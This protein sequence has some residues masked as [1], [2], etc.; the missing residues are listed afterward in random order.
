MR[1][2]KD[3]WASRSSEGSALRHRYQS[4]QAQQLFDENCDKKET[5]LFRQER[6]AFLSLEHMG[7]DNI[8]RRLNAFILQHVHK[9]IPSLING[10]NE[11]I[12]NLNGK[13][14]KLG[15]PR[16]T[17]Q[18][19]KGYLLSI[20]SGFKRIVNQALTGMFSDDFFRAANEPAKL[21]DFRRLRAVV[22]E[23]NEYFADAMLTRGSRR[24]IIETKPAL[25]V[26]NVAKNSYTKSPVPV[27]ILRSD[28]KTEVKEKM[29]GSRG[30]EL[31]GTANQFIIGELFQDHAQPW[32]ELAKTHA[33][34]VWEAVRYFVSLALQHLA[35]SHTYASILRTIVAPELATLKQ[36]LLEKLDEL[37]AHLSRSPPL[38]LGKAFL[39]KTQ[40]ARSDRVRASVVASL[41]T[42]NDH[43]TASTYGYSTESIKRAVSTLEASRDDPD[44]VAAGIIDQMEAYY[45]VSAIFLLQSYAY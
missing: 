17:I 9:N 34:R 5:A 28:L 18:Q 44:F 35:D 10:T 23:L 39:I 16:S 38:P 19:Q 31:A 32:E 40:Q 41:A 43:A 3:T 4:S 25:G 22:W 36:K 37:T 2:L 6:W 21:Y 8:A 42:T 24:R 7:K 27:D 1:F 20:S 15:L 13:L 26:Q 14:F 11:E 30:T 29:R 45:D 12:H 33:L